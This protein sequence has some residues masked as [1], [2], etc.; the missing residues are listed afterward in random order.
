MKILALP[1]DANPYQGL[2]YGELVKHGASVRYAGELTGSRTLNLLLLPFEIAFGRL[3][4]WRIVH[5][6]WVF[7]FVPAGA[8]RFP[9]MRRLGQAW[10]QAFLSFARAIGTRIVWTAHNTLPHEPVFH[11]DVAARRALLEATDLVVAHSPASLN[12]LRRRV[13]TEPSRSVII[14]LGPSLPGLDGAA[15][16]SPG[17]GGGPLKLLFL[18]KIFEYKGVEDLIEA[19][20]LLPDDG[21]RLTVIGHCPDPGLRSRLQRAAA[22]VAD[23]VTLR[24]EFVSDGEMTEAMAAADVVVLPFRRITTSSSVM[25]ALEHGRPVV[26]PDVPALAHVPA[27]CSVRFDSSVED[28]AFTLAELSRW[29]ANRL[30]RAGAAAADYANSGTWAD[31]AELTMSALHDLERSPAAR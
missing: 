9:A 26:L 23:R 8:G 16:R 29:P 31:A 1:R 24:L 28:L 15:L 14:P 5:L 3:L 6:H 19:M 27:D 2:F 21:P 22:E 13:G 25:L 17:T 10:F 4:G 30:A 7:G 20:R 12:D 18:G 11:D